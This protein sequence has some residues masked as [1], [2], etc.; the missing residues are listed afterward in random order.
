MIGVV[1]ALLIVPLAARVASGDR[2]AGL[3]GSRSEG[4]PLVLSALVAVKGEGE[5]GGGIDTLQAPLP[6][7]AAGYPAL[8][9]GWARRSGTSG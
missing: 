6:P 4:G 3:S 9:R 2:F 5:A 1:L 8:T 7:G